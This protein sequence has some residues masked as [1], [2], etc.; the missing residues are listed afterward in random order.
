MS[1]ILEA[2]TAYAERALAGGVRRFK[3]LLMRRILVPTWKLED[4][5]ATRSGVV[6]A[7]ARS[8]RRIEIVAESME[9]EGLHRPMPGFPRSLPHVLS[10]ARNITASLTEVDDNPVGFCHLWL[11]NRRSVGNNIGPSS[12]REK[13]RCW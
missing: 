1:R 12:R 9:V 3:R 2:P 6:H 5:L 11:G 7:D 8:P 4:D 13:R 10:S